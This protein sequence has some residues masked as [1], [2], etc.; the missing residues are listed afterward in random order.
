[1]LGIG[2]IIEATGGNTA[3]K[4]PTRFSGVSIDSR[5]IRKGE[6]FFALKGDRFDGHDFIADALKSGSGAVID[7]KC[8]IQNA[9]LK[10]KTV[11]LVDDTVQALHDLARY[12]R[13]RF[14]GP[15]IGIIGSN[16]K[17]TTKELVSSILNTRL[18][19]LKTTGNLNNHIGMPLSITRVDADAGAMV[20]EMGTNRPGD[21]D[22]LCKIALP[23]TG[24]VTNI[25]FEHLEGFGSLDKVRDS[26]LE[27]LPYVKRL[28]LNADDAFLMEGVRGRFEG[29]IISFGMEN[30]TA[31]LTAGDITF[32]D[33]GT[34]FSL[35]AGAGHIAVNSRLAGRFNIYNS[36]AAASA[37]YAVGFS[38]QE[39]KEGL[40]SFTGV[41]MRFEIRKEEGV[42]YLNDSYNANPSSMEE[43][44]KEL[45][46]RI[47][48][49]G[50][51]GHKHKRAIAVLGDML[52]LGSYGIDA[53]K[54]L[55]QWMSG[56]PVEVLIGVGPLM[57]LAV[58]EFRGKGIRT[59]TS[60][61]AGKELKR[62]IQEGDIV[63]IKGSRGMKM[64]KVLSVTGGGG[65]GEPGNFSRA[66][67]G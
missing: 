3:S 45:V 7:S 13:K 64:E 24:V 14:Q 4:G 11:I 27:I 62:I 63:L 29:E 46:R 9:K 49:S 44:V 53:H 37:A 50:H 21:I 32:S 8:K 31:D 22:E 51:N 6:L 12:I 30:S 2:E 26:E 28:A 41:H 43:S 18:K 65:L 17:T 5:S 25:G 23:D 54:R 36:L 48:S 19:V 58:D 1:M 57:G 34:R 55:G 33:E 15:V 67:E 38:L 59:G 16:G 56:L 40:E 35:R 42:T 10:N 66:Q 52:E 61:D 39:I 60:E 47:R 20:L